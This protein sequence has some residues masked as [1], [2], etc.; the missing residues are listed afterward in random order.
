MTT[1]Y[2]H[3]D[4]RGPIEYGAPCPI[5]T[6]EGKAFSPGGQE[7][8]TK[9]L[10]GGVPR[11]EWA[12]ETDTTTWIAVPEEALTVRA[13]R[14]AEIALEAARLE[15]KGLP[16]RLTIRYMAPFDAGTYRLYEDLLGYAPA[17]FTNV[18]RTGGTFFP[19]RAHEV[20]VNVKADAGE[21]ARMTVHEAVHAWRHATGAPAGMT[22]DDLEDEAD[23]VAEKLLPLVVACA[24]AE[25]GLSPSFKVR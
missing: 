22:E 14:A 18:P 21:V 19:D 5:L 17:T 8:E 4:G 24:A 10:A 1:D 15:L 2:E 7:V 9:A 12:P 13:K 11:T 16:D 20:W 3:K 25:G 6:F 23:G